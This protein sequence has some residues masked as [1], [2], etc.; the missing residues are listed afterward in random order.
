MVE[1]DSRP[2]MD[3]QLPPPPP[4][5]KDI[6]Q[7]GRQPPRLE[8]PPPP[9]EK[10]GDKTPADLALEKEGGEIMPDEFRAKPPEPAESIDFSQVMPMPVSA[11]PADPKEEVKLKASPVVGDAAPEPPPKS[12]AQIAWET[13]LSGRI[14]VELNIYHSCFQSTRRM[15]NLIVATTPA[16]SADIGE[17]Q[18]TGGRR[19]PIENA[20]P[21]IAL[22]VY[23]QVRYEMRD[24]VKD[25]RD[26]VMR[27]LKVLGIDPKNL[28][29]KGRR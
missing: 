19:S 6:P 27:A 20:E 3:P 8:T 9:P 23:R 16:D 25:E 2:P 5:R 15:V 10:P 4:D 22:E 17:G 11:A 13:E 26:E 1:P 28:K 14:N 12:P 18:W 24:Q 21:E 29:G 7:P